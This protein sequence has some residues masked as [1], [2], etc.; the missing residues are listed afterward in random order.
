LFVEF[1]YNP[2]TN[3]VTGQ[4]EQRLK[5]WVSISDALAKAIIRLNNR[6][7]GVHISNP[8]NKEIAEAIYLYSRYKNFVG[9]L[10]KLTN[11]S[12]LF[13]D[14]VLLAKTLTGV[15]GSA[16]DRDNHT[17]EGGGRGSQRQ[18]F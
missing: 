9:F 13:A 3:R 7:S 6:Q 16:F 18:F 5:S 2:L 1:L 14:S 17:T 10:Y 11:Q 15:L 12:F 8:A 4:N